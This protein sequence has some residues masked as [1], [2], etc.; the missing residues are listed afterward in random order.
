MPAGIAS[1][2]AKGGGMI[3][4]LACVALMA[5]IMGSDAAAQTVSA[6]PPVESVTVIGTRD[7][8]RIEQFMNS[9]AAPTALLGKLARWRT[10]IC[11]VAVGLRPAAIRFLLQRLRGIAAEVGA[12]VDAHPDCRANIEIVFTTTPQ[13]L[14]DNV[15]KE[16]AVYLGY[17]ASSSQTDR[18]ARV[19]RPIQAWYTTQSTDLAG[20]AKVDSARTIGLGDNAE[21]AAAL[22]MGSTTGLR[23]RDGRKS[24][25]YHVIV[26]ADPNKLAEH[27]IGSIADYVAF[28]SLSQLAS[29]DRCQELPSI[30]DMLV[31]GC[32]PVGEITSNDLAFLR[33]LYRMPPDGDLRMQKDAIS[34]EMAK[35]LQGR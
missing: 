31:P 4:G 2:P 22:M 29:L 18:L 1:L 10:G 16:H 3:R 13:G 8:Q 28:L 5:I 7:R 12:P 15:R 17:S 25:L 19:I 14:L 26:A 6:S 21:F 32:P 35:A 9:F 23:A 33:G 24:E 11:P 30:M 20:Q 27:E 34:F